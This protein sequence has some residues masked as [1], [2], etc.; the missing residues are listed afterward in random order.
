MLILIQA[1]EDFLRKA[2]LGMQGKVN[3]LAHPVREMTEVDEL[4]QMD[5]QPTSTVIIPDFEKSL[6]K[7]SIKDFINAAHR[8]QFLL[9]SRQ[10]ERRR[11]EEVCWNLLLIPTV[12]HLNRRRRMSHDHPPRKTVTLPR[13][14]TRIYESLVRVSRHLR[15]LC[16][17]QGQEGD[18]LG[19]NG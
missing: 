18:L 3:F 7:K 2:Q 6:K 17:C 1:R 13:W 14:P 11:K 8:E 5:W 10:E 19:E 16:K 9:R 4:S 12:I 15:Q